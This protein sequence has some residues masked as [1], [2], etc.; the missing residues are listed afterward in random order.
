MKLWDYFTRGIFYIH[1]QFSHTY[2]LKKETI[3]KH[4]FLHSHVALSWE[5]KAILENLRKNVLKY[6]NLQSHRFTFEG[7]Q[8]I[9]NRILL[10]KFYYK[11][12]LNTI[13]KFMSS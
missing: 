2:F 13:D 11:L 6:Y 3:E 8:R 9:K 4:T 5:K 1:S 10:I 7:F 12:V